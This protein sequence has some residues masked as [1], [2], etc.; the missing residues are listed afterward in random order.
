MKMI[1]VVTL[2]ILLI[3]PWYGI[4]TK[5]FTFHEGSSDPDELS[6][7]TLTNAPDAPL[8]DHFIIC[9]SHKQQQIGTRNTTAFYFL[10]AERNS[11]GTHFVY[12]VTF[13]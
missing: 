1:S 4:G 2:S 12:V 8:P 10:K 3:L 6:S 5:V 11:M 9:S 13:F 7:A